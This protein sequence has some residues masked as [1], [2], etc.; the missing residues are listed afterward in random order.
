VEATGGQVSR[1]EGWVIYLSTQSDEPPAGVFQ[2]KLRYFRG[3]RDGRIIDTKS[4]GILYEFP[5]KMLDDQAYL[6]P[7]FFYITNPNL[8]RS[9]SAEWLED[10][11]RKVRESPGALQQFLSKHLNVELG[12]NLR[13]DRWAGAD[14]WQTC[15][16]DGLVTLQDL[17]NRCEVVVAGIDGGGL[18]DLLGFGAMGREKDT[19]KWLH[20]GKAWAHRCVL[21]RRKEIAPRLL[22]FAAS[23]DLVLVEDD[24][25]DDV[26]D[27]A[28]LVQLMD[29]S[30]LLDRIGVDQAGI[31]GI[32]DAIE[33]RNIDR[34]RIV[35]VPQGWRMVGAIKTTERK[36]AGKSLLH[37]GQPLMA[38][39]VGNARAVARGNAVVIE[40]QT[41]GSAKIDPVMAMLNCIAL[42]SM[43]PQPQ[44][45]L[46]QHFAY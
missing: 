30:G 16:A 15:R 22:D 36:L 34:E 42:M 1:D 18:D 21:E 7:E 3:V 13:H 12:L 14:H 27:V 25:E 9:V 31:G 26:E 29:R 4:L 11:L 2:D 39:S 40:K 43:N 44:S 41:A 17:L 19:G 32:A 46:I 5:Q 38:W 20:W 33:A 24:S 6:R 28:D 35:G 37:A 23:G 10:Q 8:G 45:K